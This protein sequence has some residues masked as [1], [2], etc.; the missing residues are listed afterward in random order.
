M[1]FVNECFHSNRDLIDGE[2]LGGSSNSEASCSSSSGR[3]TSYSHQTKLELLMKLEKSGLPIREF[4]RLNNISDTCLRRWKKNRDSLK[5]TKRCAR[6]LAGGGRGSFFPQLESKLFAWVTERNKQGLRVK[7]KYIIHRALL[8]KDEMIA[9]LSKDGSQRDFVLQLKQFTASINWYT[10]FKKRFR[11]SVR[12]PTT[13]RTLPDDFAEISR[14]FIQHVQDIIEA[15]RVSVRNI[16]NFDQV[17]RYFESESTST[18]TQV[19]TKSVITKKA[20]TSHKRFTVTP[21]I[22]AGGEF[23]AL[24]LLFSNLKNK[25]TVDQ[26]CLVDVNKTGMFNELCLKRI[27]DECIIKKCQTVFRESVLILL[28]SY[29]THIKFV[30]ANREMYSRRNV[31]FAIIPP[32][33][34]GMLQPLDVAVNRSLQQSYSDHFD[35]HL[36]SSLADPDKRTKCGNIKMPKYSE[37][38]EWVADWAEGLTRESIAKAFTLCGLVPATVFSVEN[39][40][41]PL[42]DCFIGD[43]DQVTWNLEHGTTIIAEDDTLD[44]DDWHT[45]EVPNALA[46]ALYVGMGITEDYA[47]W[48]A[49]FQDK[50]LCGIESD[51]DLNEVFDADDRSCL[52]KGHLTESRVELRAAAKV[53][54]LKLNVREYDLA[55]QLV[56]EN[57][58]V[59]GGLES[60][61]EIDLFFQSNYLVGV[62]I[63]PK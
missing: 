50:I 19:G 53:F 52:R 6:R 1:F 39:L 14:N 56:D 31:F 44:P 27:I 45:F 8:I 46:Q 10:R 58:Y 13:S 34:T 4:S 17:P 57:I 59:P 37:L 24:H 9:E 40:H 63:D 36:A 38:S 21:V 12:R 35:V 30:D 11:L 60:G 41:K 7:C 15:N 28:D 61:N 26:R 3:R 22:S 32:R 54:N 29:G 2:S 23:L 25:P 18:I 51:A 16:I 5:T 49:E 43:M 55:N 42:R 20:S 33:M 47:Y 62:R 48:L